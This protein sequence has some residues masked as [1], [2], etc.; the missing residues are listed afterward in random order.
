MNGWRFVEQ[1]RL[2]VGNA[3]PDG[4]ALVPWCG[5]ALAGT[6][7]Y[8]PRRS[9]IVVLESYKSAETY[10][11]I[12]SKDGVSRDCLPSELFRVVERVPAAPQKLGRL[13]KVGE[14]FW[15]EVERIDEN[16]YGSPG[17]PILVRFGPDKTDEL[18]IHE[19]VLGVD[20]AAK[21]SELE[22]ARARV[23]EL[24]RELGGGE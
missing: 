18:W 5:A 3:L 22:A 12:G 10:V 24:E 20:L 14:R 4:C 9:E 6:R 2:R 17:Y 1:E 13:P 21:R 7:M 16:P 8:R 19:S 23:A 15:I 11:R